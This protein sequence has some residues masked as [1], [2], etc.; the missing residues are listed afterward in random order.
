MEEIEKLKSML[1]TVDKPTTNNSQ[2]RNP[3]MCSLTLSSKALVSFAFSVFGNELRNVWILD[4]GATDHMS[5]ISNKFKTYNPYPSNRKIV[6]ADGTTTTVTGIGDVQ[7]TP[8]LILKNVLHVPQLSTNLVSDRGSG[9]RIGL[10]KEHDGLYYLDTSSQPEFSKS[11][12]ST[13]FSPSN[14][15]VIWLH[16]RRLGHVSF[17]AL[18]IMFPSLFK[19]FDVQS[20][21]CDICECYIV[22]NKPYFITPYLQGE[23]DTLK[24]KELKFSSLELSTSESSKSEFQESILQ[25]DVVEEKKEDRKIYDWFRFDQV[26]TRKGD[27]IVVTRQ[28]QSSKPSSRNE[29][30]MSESNLNSTP[31]TD[32]SSSSKSPCP[33]P[34]SLDQDLHLP[35]AV[36]KKPQECTKRP[37]YPL[38]HFVSFEK[39]SPSHQSFLSTLNTVSI[40]NSLSEALSKKEWKLAMEV[41]MDAL[42]K[43]GTWE[44]VDLPK[45]KKVVDCKWVYAVKFKADGPLERYKARLVAKGYT[46]TYGV[47]YRETFAPVAKMNTVRILLSLAINFDW[48]LQQYD[49]KNAFFSWRVRRGD[50]YEH[51]TGIQWG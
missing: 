2:S 40:P 36:R 1:E 35:I 8:N 13:L 25:S 45:N 24:D 47:D 30:I 32:H 22:E 46:Q 21:H 33:E 5:H 16:H 50:L 6:V 29:V 11:A 23:L 27:P 19:G 15:D 3:G 38:S 14:K 49:V 26:Y 44:L 28:E 51:S 12:L 20:F 43:N 17:S 41:E 34:L 7:V 42:E 37:L 10:A 31:P 4:S 48:E 39:F 18:K 9:K